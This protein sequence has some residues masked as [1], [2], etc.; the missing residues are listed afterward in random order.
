LYIKLQKRT[1]ETYF[2]LDEGINTANQESH[3]SISAN[4]QTM[5][6]TSNRPGG[7]GGMDI[8]K[9]NKLPNNTWGKAQN[10]GPTIN[11]KYN[12]NGPFIHPNGKILYFSSAGHKSM[13][14]LDIYR[15]DLENGSWTTPKNIGYPI[16]STEDDVYYVPT[17]DGKRAYLSSYRKGSLGKTDIFLI[18]TPNQEIKGLFVLKGKIVSTDKSAIGNAII[19]VK[20]KGRNIGM[21][22]TNK[23]TGKFLFIVEAGKNYDIE[24]F[25]EGF[26][27]FKTK[28][29]VPLEYANKENNS[30]ITLVPVSLKTTAEK[31]G[32]EDEKLKVNFD[33][34]KIKKEVIKKPEPVKPVIKKKIIEE[35][36]QNPIER[37]SE[38]IIDVEYQAEEEI[39]PDTYYTIQIK[40]MKF[41]VGKKYFNKIPDK[42]N[43]KE[44]LGTDNITRYTYRIFEDYNEALK[45]KQECRQ[46][47][48][49]DA[50]IKTVING[51]VV[52]LNTKF[53]TGTN[54]YTI[55]VMALSNPKPLYFFNDIGHIKQYVHKKVFFW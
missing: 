31:G 17:T 30:V 51:Q 24:I 33:K 47:G 50:F 43:I 11:T 10:L 15:T 25:A 52:D 19:S 39:V 12:E 54:T 45:M 14:G 28:L 35:V 49:W 4:A 40:A 8:Y 22:N 42:S 18:K 44:T 23:A 46:K 26:K 2:R 55:Q 38:K 21:Y 53:V 16:N 13:G 32:Y 7:Y 3:I 37:N 20:Y 48:Y 5:Y 34:S 29:N 41:P 1:K 27:T 36:K 9:V 6:F